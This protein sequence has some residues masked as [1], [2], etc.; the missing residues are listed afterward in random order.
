MNKM[1]VRWCQ[2]C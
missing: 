1:S 2:E